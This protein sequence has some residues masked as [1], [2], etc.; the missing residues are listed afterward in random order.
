MKK[1]VLAFDSFK[2]SISAS[3]ACTAAAKGILQD[4]PDSEIISIP[5]SDGG[6]GMVQ[7]FMPF[8]KLEKIV[9]RAHDPLM[10][11]IEA[12]YAIAPESKT[13]YMEMAST[14]GLTRLAIHERNPLET[15][16]YG[17]G[18][19]ITDA[20]KQGCCHIVMGI[21]GSATCDGGK[22]MLEALKQNG[23]LAEN[24]VKNIDITVACDVTNPLYGTNGAAYI[25]APQ[26]GATPEQV[27]TLDDRLRQWAAETEKKGFATT[28]DAFHPGSGA[29]G[30]LGYA[31]LTYLHARLKSGIDIVLDTLGFDKA[32]SNCNLIITGEGKSD[33]QTL[34]G[35]VPQGILK[36]ACKAHVPVL[37]L[38]GAVEDKDKLLEAGFSEVVSINEGDNRC[39][40]ELMSHD[41][42]CQ[43]IT[44]SVQRIINQMF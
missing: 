15:T 38:S 36:R 24:F 26:K 32:I 1:I 30:G 25:F 4:S 14:S 10:R 33:A 18:E 37:L 19:M 40:E 20:I 13:A 35:K 43:N 16:T 34:M 5:M 23:I 41:V 42:A 22:G 17:V 28:D 27:K 2:G 12:V 44:R 6:E 11:P 7:C 3:Q 8:L 31:L 39:L 21:G 29:A 9:F